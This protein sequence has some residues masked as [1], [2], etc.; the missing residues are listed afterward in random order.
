MFKITEQ[1][2][3][4]AY[5]DL[6]KETEDFSKFSIKSFNMQSNKILALRLALGLSQKNFALLIKVTPET[7]SEWEN[8]RTIP[9]NENLRKIVLFAKYHK[10]KFQEEKSRLRKV[11]KKFQNNARTL[12]KYS[13]DFKTMQAINV[14]ANKS[15]ERTPD[16]KELSN[17]LIKNGIKFKEQESVIPFS[18]K[19]GTAIVDFLIE[20]NG[21][22]ILIE[23]SDFGNLS[24][25]RNQRRFKLERARR[26]ALKAFRIRKYLPKAKLVVFIKTAI[27]KNHQII[28]VL[29]EA[30]D[31]VI[32]N[33]KTKLIKEIRL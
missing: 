20:K 29:N 12:P 16:E 32:L 22:L 1:Q 26:L 33:D 11:F 18:V 23:C 28:E 15:K 4:K 31:A 17:Y 21:H 7:V 30:F 3:L 2:V 25:W 27:P 5:R 14:K 6:K 9:S 10:D 13:F 24:K 19:A 8:G